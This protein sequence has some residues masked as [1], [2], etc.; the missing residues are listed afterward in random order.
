[1]DA[2]SINL[3]NQPVDPPL[4]QREKGTQGAVRLLS[5]GRRLGVA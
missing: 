5:Y 3:L 2:L 1:M 4:S